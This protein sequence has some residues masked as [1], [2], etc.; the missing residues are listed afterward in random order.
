MKAEIVTG[1]GFGDEGK[2]TIVDYLCRKAKGKRWVVRFKGGSQCGHTVDADALNRTISHRFAQFGSGT[3]AG[4]PTLLA[5]R[6]LVN[7]FTLIHEANA[8]YGKGLSHP[9]SMVF[10]SANCWVTT[11]YH[12]ILNQAREL[13]RNSRHGSCGMGIGETVA[14]AIARPGD[15]LFISDLANQDRTHAKLSRILSY[16]EAQAEENNLHLNCLLD[17]QFSVENIAKSYTQFLSSGVTVIPSSE[18]LISLYDHVV[19]EGAQGVLLDEWAGFHPYTT[20]SNTTADWAWDLLAKVHNENAREIGVIRAFH[21]RHGNGPFPSQITGDP[22]KIAKVLAED[23]NGTNEWQG[24]FRVGMLDLPLLKY[25]LCAAQ[26]VGSIA[27]TWCD[28]QYPAVVKSYQNL[29]QSA[30]FPRTGRSG[31]DP[32]DRQSQTEALYNAN[33]VIEFV[34]VGIDKLIEHETG[35]KVSILSMGRKSCDKIEI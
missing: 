26:T 27:V 16:V 4:V 1:L 15:V 24:D 2:G 31:L 12:R 5:D 7:P 13:A 17:P 35:A 21:T 10:I 25:A 22:G 33:P 29:N 18:E 11:P 8:L 3:L 14:H 6:V 19:F 9:M 23:D 30:L 32:I 28:Q 20:W 34:K